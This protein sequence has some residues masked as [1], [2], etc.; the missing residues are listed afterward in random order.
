M[1]DQ[2]TVAQLLGIESERVK[3]RFIGSEPGTCI[4]LG[5]EFHQKSLRTDYVFSILALNDM[6]YMNG[7]LALGKEKTKHELKKGEALHFM[8]DL[9]QTWSGKGGGNFIWF[10]WRNL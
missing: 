5:Q 7:L 1:G 4:E 8:G 3:S 2:T 10:Y 6:S 9:P